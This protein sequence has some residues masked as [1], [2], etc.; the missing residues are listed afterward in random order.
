[1]HIT[2]TKHSKFEVYC[3][4]ENN[5]MVIALDANK[6]LTVIVRAIIG[7]KLVEACF[8]FEK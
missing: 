2:L 5:I 4:K 3:K 7:D 1:M 6:S 8:L